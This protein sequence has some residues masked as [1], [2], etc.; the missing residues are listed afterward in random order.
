[1]S[2]VNLLAGLFMLPFMFPPVE[3]FMLPPV[4]L[5]MLPPVVEPALLFVWIVTLALVTVTLALL[6]LALALPALVL[7]P[8]PHAE[9]PATPTNARSAKVLRIDRS[10]EL[11]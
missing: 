3:L 5:F 11:L 1:M 4:V 2:G 6:T 10:P 8:P 9:R 7:S